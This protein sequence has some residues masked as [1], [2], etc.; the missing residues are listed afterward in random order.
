MKTSNASA[1]ELQDRIRNLAAGMVLV[2]A[3]TRSS[4]PRK[5]LIGIGLFVVLIG[6]LVWIS[7]RQA[8]RSLQAWKSQMTARGERFSIEEIVP[9]ALSPV[10]TNLSRFNAAANQLRSLPIEPGYFNRSSLPG[11]AKQWFFG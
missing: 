10:D 11:Q 4:F 2:Y 6:L 3:M 5:I 1:K 9:T 7:R 8:Q